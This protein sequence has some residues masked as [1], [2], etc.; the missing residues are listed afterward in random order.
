MFVKP[1]FVHELIEIT[2]GKCLKL[3]SRCIVKTPLEGSDIGKISPRIYCDYTYK[4]T[5]GDGGYFSHSIINFF[6]EVPKHVEF[7]NKFNQCLLY[8]QLPHEAKKAA[9]CGTN[10]SGKSSCARIFFGLMNRLKIVSV[11]KEKTFGLSTMDEDTELTFI[12]EWS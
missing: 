6:L 9:V 2:G 12:D 7:L 11:L 3:S 5:S 8:G 4:R 1:T 10:S